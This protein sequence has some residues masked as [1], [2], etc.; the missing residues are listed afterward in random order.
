MRASAASSASGFS[1]S[2]CLPVTV[3]DAR[4]PDAHHADAPTVTVT[5]QAK[6]REGAGERQ[7]DCRDGRKFSRVVKLD[8]GENFIVVTATLPGHED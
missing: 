8:S 5:G 2:T 4:P 7:Q 1:Q 3:T 6:G